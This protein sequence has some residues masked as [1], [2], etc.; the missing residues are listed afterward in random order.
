MMHIAI[1]AQLLSGAQSYRGAGVSNYSRQLLHH[2]GKR[3]S[4]GTKYQLTAFV[5]TPEFTAPG[6]TLWQTPPIAQQPWLRIAW[7]QTRLPG[8]L[9]QM[10]ADLVHGLVNVLPLTTRV[11][12]VVTVHDLSFLH[13]PEKLPALRR[14]YLTGLC[15]A[16]VR[17]AAHVIAVSQQTADDLTQ[18]FGTG[19]GKISVIYNGVADHFSPGEPGAV[20]HFRRARNLPARFLL[21]LGTLEPRKNLE[22]LVRAYA[23]WRAQAS[24]EDQTVKLVIA[25]G[26]GWFYKTIFQ[27]VQTLGI[28]PHVLFPGFITDGELADWYRAAEGFVYPSLFEGFGLP[29]AEAMACGTPVLCSQTQS[30][31][32]VAGEAA[33]TFPPQD[34][35]A[36]ADGLALL[37]AQPT[38]RAALRERGLQRAQHF[39]WQRTVDATL[40]VYEQVCEM[41]M[42]RQSR[43]NHHI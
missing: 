31:R 25:G 39:T 18:T 26:K 10:Q 9:R 22:M 3:T 8:L 12:G 33:L 34:E 6:V 32:E 19:A 37:I 24:D 35:R 23:R 16:S 2:L 20:T 30:L 28:E 13:L 1:N 42:R 36:L 5:S 14:L 15:R 7:E 29:V 4:A 11:P 27:Q 38:R 43:H 41:V 17:K 40:G 21:Y